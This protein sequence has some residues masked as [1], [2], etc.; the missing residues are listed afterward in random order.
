MKDLYCIHKQLG[1]TPLEA[2][3]RLREE[4][5]I[6]A[7]VP[8]TYAGRLDPAAEGL[9]V[10]LVGDE[11]RNKD[12]YSGLDKTYKA[13]ILLGVSTDSLDLLGLPTVAVSERLSKAITLE[14]LQID[15]DLAGDVEAYLESKKGIFEQQYPAY[16]SKTVD[17][18]QLHSHARAGNDVELPTHQVKLYSYKNVSVRIADRE[19]VVAR[20]NLVLEKVRGDFRQEEISAE[21][22]RVED[23][24]PEELFI[25]S[26][27]IA[28]GTGF[29]VR[30]LA[31]DL[32]EALG[33]KACLY[34]LV[35]TKVGDFDGVT[36]FKSV[37]E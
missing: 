10:V 35:R 36:Q 29:Y 27:E 4:A 31:A 5:G 33:T 26:L 37:V 25:V 7:D 14:G 18:V 15:T 24:L 8:M 28:V 6:A 2:L 32:G 13:E 34:K 16:S 9:L 11:C 20:V 30:Q 23:S 22:A 1:E 17:G 19:D 3:E 21:W 12:S